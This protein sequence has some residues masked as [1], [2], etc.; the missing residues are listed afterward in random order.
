VCAPDILSELADI[1]S[2]YY[3][4]NADEIIELY[5]RKGCRGQPQLFQEMFGIQASIRDA[6]FP[7]DDPPPSIVLP[8]RYLVISGGWTG[9]SHYKAWPRKKWDVVVD[10]A[11]RSG[12][13][14]VQIGKD[15]EPSIVGAMNVRHLG[16]SQQMG[17]L[18]GAVAYAGCDGFFSHAAAALDV[19]GVVL[20][21]ITPPEVWGHPGQ[22][23]VIS[24]IARNLWWTHYHWAWD[25]G[26]QSIMSAIDVDSVSDAIDTVLGGGI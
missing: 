4:F 8:D 13:C 19:P 11:A 24:P 1:E 18:S 2:R 9:T 3:R 12:V 26:C 7:M 10:R 21:G 17:I 6:I 20:W 5:R 16:L 22:T 14:S 23:D 25:E 15:D